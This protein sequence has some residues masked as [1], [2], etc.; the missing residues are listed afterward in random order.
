MS[1]ETETGSETEAAGKSPRPLN[2]KSIRRRLDKINAG[3]TEGPA[4]G[5]AKKL[6]KLS[7]QILAQIAAGQIRNPA[8][9]ARAFIDGK[10][11]APEAPA[12]A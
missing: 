10:S 4:K 3:G 7:E 9:A 5:R 1:E 12:E 11:A 2:A 8:A 6:A